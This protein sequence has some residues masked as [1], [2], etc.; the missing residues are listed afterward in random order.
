MAGMFGQK[1]V[2]PW[3]RLR[4]GLVLG[5]EKLWATVRAIM[6][7]KEGLEEI[8]WQQRMGARDVAERVRQI[9]SAEKNEGVRIWARVKLG[10]ERGVDIAREAGYKDGSAVTQ[11]VKRLER[12]AQDNTEL[13]RKLDELRMRLSS[14]K[15]VLPKWGAF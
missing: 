4:G 6:K 10:G 12:K 3:A 11:I 15:G 14:V 5:S 9:V 13:Q 2:S 7:E 8:R 1:A